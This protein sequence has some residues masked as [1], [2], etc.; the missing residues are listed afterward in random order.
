MSPN[1]SLCRAPV[2]SRLCETTTSWLMSRRWCTRVSNCAWEYETRSGFD[3]N[4][5]TLVNDSLFQLFD[6]VK[7]DL[8]YPA[9]AITVY[10]VDS[11]QNCTLL[12]NLTL[13]LSIIIRRALCKLSRILSDSS[14]ANQIHIAALESI[15]SIYSLHRE[16]FA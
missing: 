5:E 1:Y 16:D 4:L 7:H 11:T 15:H 9:F 14:L 2:T 8:G 10:D 6:V 13:I 12:N 3:D